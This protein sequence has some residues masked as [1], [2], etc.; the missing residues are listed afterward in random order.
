MQLYLRSPSMPLWR[1]RGQLLI[2]MY[3]KQA[4]SNSPPWFW[5]VSVSWQLDDICWTKK[6]CISNTKWNYRSSSASQSSPV[7]QADGHLN[8]KSCLCKKTLLS[9][10]RDQY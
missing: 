7:Y 3:R 1:G 4:H 5:S 9:Q 10:S 2:F 6:L 8:C